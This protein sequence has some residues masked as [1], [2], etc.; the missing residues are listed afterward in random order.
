MARASYTSKRGLAP[1][2]RTSFAQGSLFWCNCFEPSE[3]RPQRYVRRLLTARAV[4]G[5]NEV[6]Q[7][8]ASHQRF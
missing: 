2:E 4:G 6:L 3:S 1:L 7:A 8:G 5:Q